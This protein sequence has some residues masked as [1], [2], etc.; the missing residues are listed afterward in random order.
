MELPA[1]FINGKSISGAW[2]VDTYKAMIDAEIGRAAALMEQRRLPPSEIY[3]A[4][5]AAAN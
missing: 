4:I 2:P 5:P 1:L 3:E